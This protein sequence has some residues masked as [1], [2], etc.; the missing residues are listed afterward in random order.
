MLELQRQRLLAKLQQLDR[1]LAKSPGKNAGAA[2]PGCRK[3][4]RCRGKAQ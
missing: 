2:L 1:S 3:T 4:S